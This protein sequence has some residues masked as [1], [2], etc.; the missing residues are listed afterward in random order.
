MIRI[1][2]KKEVIQELLQKGYKIIKRPYDRYDTVIAN[3]GGISK[4]IEDIIKSV[5]ECRVDENKNIVSKFTETPLDMSRLSDGSKTVIYVYFRAI[6]NKNK[7]EIISISSCG[8]NAIKYILEHFND[9]DITLYLNHWQF[10]D[11]IEQEFKL[12]DEIIHNTNE[13]YNIA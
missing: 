10:P 5:D 8:P 9:Q 4:E 7:N 6:V 11:S 2:T 12:D 13:I 3:E 1:I